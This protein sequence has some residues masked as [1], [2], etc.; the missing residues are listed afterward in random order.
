MISLIE[1]KRVVLIIFAVLVNGDTC[2][3]PGELHT[4]C[5]TFNPFI[6]L[7]LSYF[8]PYIFVLTSCIILHFVPILSFSPMCVCWVMQKFCD[9]PKKSIYFKK[10]QTSKVSV[11]QESTILINYQFIVMFFHI[12]DSSKESTNYFP[13]ITDVD[14]MIF[15][16]I[17]NIIPDRII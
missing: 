10:K 15:H 11:L 12:I 3:E 5:M 8:F 2:N 17:W 4:V 16:I 13:Y 7:I 14:L 1:K 6:L 9:I